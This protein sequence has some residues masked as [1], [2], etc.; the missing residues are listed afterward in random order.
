MSKT[1]NIENTTNGD[2]ERDEAQDAPVESVEADVTDADGATAESAAEIDDAAASVD[3]DDE[4]ERLYTKADVDKLLAQAAESRLRVQAEYDNYRRRTIREKEQW[5]ADALEGFVKDLLP[6]FDSF[7]KAR[8]IEVGEGALQAM[9]DGLDVTH[10]QLRG[11]LDR[12]GIAVIDPVGEPF[13]PA[14]QEALMRQSSPDHE[15]N[16]VITVFERGYTIGGR[17]VRPARVVVSQE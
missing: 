3:A 9:H 16:T 8:E 17:L 13:D 6:V 1:E 10:K 14:Q 5:I 12:Y 11:V 4:P 15:P 2:G 7:D